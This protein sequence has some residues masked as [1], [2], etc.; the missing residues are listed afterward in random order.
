MVIDPELSGEPSTAIKSTMRAFPP[1]LFSRI[2]IPQQYKWADLLFSPKYQGA[3]F[4]SSFKANPNSRIVTV[5]DEATGAE[6]KRYVNKDRW[7]GYGPVTTMYSD[8]G[9]SL[10]H[11][12]V[13]TFQRC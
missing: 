1:P 10:V 13:R 9:V 4:P 11:T 7:K 5:V 12:H 3:K 6:K 2:N 8:S